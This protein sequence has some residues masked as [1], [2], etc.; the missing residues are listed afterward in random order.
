MPMRHLRYLF[1]FLSLFAFSFTCGVS[2]ANPSARAE[3]AS[4]IEPFSKLIYVDFSLNKAFQKAGNN[5]KLIYFSGEVHE[6][7][8]EEIGNDIFRSLNPIII[9]ASSEHYL[10][11]ECADGETIYQSEHIPFDGDIFEDYIDYICLDARGEGKNASVAGYGLFVEPEKNPGATYA[12]QRVWLHNPNE[13]G[14]YDGDDWG[15]PCKNAV[16]YLD[17]GEWKVTVMD[18]TVNNFNNTTY[19]FADIPYEVTKVHFLR[20]SQSTN[21]KYLHYLEAPLT[22]LAYGVCYEAGNTSYE[23]FENLDRVLVK[24][25]SAALLANVVDAFITY[26]KRPSN[27]P[28]TSTIQNVY[29][30]WF[31]NRSATKEELKEQKILDYA[32]YVANGNSYEGLVKSVS[33]SVNDKWNGLCNQAGV[34]PNTGQLRSSLFGFDL[35]D[36]KIPLLIMGGAVGV[37][38]LLETVVIFVRKKNDAK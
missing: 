20:L 24:G 8:L 34:D 19:Y 10:Y 16:S 38:I 12:T 3:A 1:A 37:L 22:Y 28:T 18:S 13:H 6:I 5:A 26:G 29:S 21:H 2:F 7:G 30:T 32:G 11:F 15:T 35:S 25:A 31:E 23:D 36:A 33:Y 9:A 27:G 17:N 14:F 4:S